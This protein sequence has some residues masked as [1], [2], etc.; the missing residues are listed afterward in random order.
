MLDEVLAY[1]VDQILPMVDKDDHETLQNALKIEDGKDQVTLFTCTPY[2]VNSHRLLVRGTRV[3]YNGEEEVTGSVADTM[4]HCDPE[5]LYVISASRNCDHG[6]D[7]CDHE[8]RIRKKTTQY[9]E[10]RH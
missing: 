1:Q 3:P 8:S 9:I 6:S 4:L 7:H 10:E 2:G 5:L